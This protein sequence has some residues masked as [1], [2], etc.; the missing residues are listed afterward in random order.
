MATEVWLRDPTSY[1]LDALTAGYT[2]FVFQWW[3]L[4]RAKIDPLSYMRKWCVG[5]DPN[6]EFMVIGPQGASHYRGLSSHGNPIAVYPVWTPDMPI[7]DLEDMM[8]CPVGEE[9]AG[10]FE[11]MPDGLR[12]RSGQEHRVVIGKLP[13]A[14]SGVTKGLLQEINSLALRYED[15]KLHLHEMQ[16]FGAMFSNEFHSVDFDPV[17]PQT[18]NAQWIYLPN[19]ILLQGKDRPEWPAFEEWINLLGFQLPQVATDRR[20]LT[21][22]NIRSVEWAARYFTSDLTLKMRY[23][24]TLDEAGVP[25]VRFAPATQGQRKRALTAARRSLLYKERDKNTD[26]VICN[27][28]MYRSTCKLMR[29]DS[30][31][32][33]KGTDTVA[34]ADAFGSRNADRIIT[35]LSDL[36]KMQADRTERAVEEEALSGE[37]DP[38]VTKMMNSLFKNGTSL[39]KLLNPELNGKGV[40]VNV[41]NQNVAAVSTADPRQLV[42]NAV[43]ALEAQGIARE[44]ITQDMLKVIIQNPNAQVATAPPPLAIEGVVMPSKEVA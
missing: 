29:V 39:A 9:P 44:D 17:G 34:L 6:V 40:T 12:P 15:C 43:R 7:G 27:W 10:V 38:E 33:Y 41:N 22:F 23:R 32:I 20:I 8:A 13:F 37:T 25:K 26:F 2:R 30:V 19:G 16:H 24:P 5:L 31:C 11:D 21:A 3:K 18:G 1:A 36:L 14:T 35:G 42:A 28:C 4:Q